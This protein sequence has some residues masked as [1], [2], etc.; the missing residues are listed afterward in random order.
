MPQLKQGV[1]AVRHRAAPS[2]RA[3]TG[4]APRERRIGRRSRVR[5]NHAR[6]RT[7]GTRQAGDEHHDAVDD[8]GGDAGRAQAGRGERPR[9]HAL[10]RPPAGDAR[11]H[12]GQQHEQRQRQQPETA[13]RWCPRS[14]RRSGRWP[15]GRRRPAPTRAR[16]PATPSG[17][18]ARRGC[19]RPPRAGPAPTG[20]ARRPAAPEP[21]STTPTAATA[22]AIATSGMDELHGRRQREEN[23]DGQDDLH[24]LP[25]GALPRDGPQPAADV[26]TSRPWLTPRW[27]SP[28]DPAGQRDVEEQRPVVRRHRSGQRQVDAE[29]AGHDL[30]PPGTAHGGQHRDGRRRRQR[31]GR[32]PC[33]CRRGTGR[34]QAPDQDGE[35]HGGAAR[36]AHAHSGPAH[37][38]QP[39]LSSRAGPAGRRGPR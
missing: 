13:A 32:R 4:H 35:R 20:S 10:A 21:T 26:A 14:A 27:T 36:R 22:S 39:D 1:R 18:A 15:R 25:G 37:P 29:A 24:D 6:T 31:R 2:G 3:A 38:E 33:G 12:H 16:W 30:P 9:R 5:R 19:R 34:A 23:D 11:Q 8:G 28:D 17:R 7:S